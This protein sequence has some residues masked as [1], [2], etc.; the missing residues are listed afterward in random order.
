PNTHTF[1]PRNQTNEKSRD[2]I[3]LHPLMKCQKVN[4]ILLKTV[5]KAR[6]HH[7]PFSDASRLFPISRH[8]HHAAPLEAC[9]ATVRTAPVDS[10]G[11]VLPLPASAFWKNYLV[12]IT[13]GTIVDQLR[14]E[15]RLHGS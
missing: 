3:L 14:S 8:H 7:N 11:F 2:L 12:R 15:S 1:F 4:R 5:K 13:F 6:P 9:T 10:P